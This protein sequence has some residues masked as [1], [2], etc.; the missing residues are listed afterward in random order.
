MFETALTRMLAPWVVALFV[1]AAGFPVTLVT[2]GACAIGWSDARP[3]LA[4]RGAGA[5]LRRLLAPSLI[6]LIL[7]L[8]V[9]P[10]TCATRGGCAERGAWPMLLIPVGWGA[11]LGAGWRIASRHPWRAHPLAGGLVTTALFLQ[12]WIALAATVGAAAALVGG[13][14]P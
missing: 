3:V 4:E 12:A 5:L 14:L 7:L 10:F 2:L 8:V 11:A 1:L 13:P 9:G 6:P